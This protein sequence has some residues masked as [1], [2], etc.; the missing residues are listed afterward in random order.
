MISGSPVPH[1]EL[2]P[3][4][5]MCS[6]WCVESVKRTGLRGL[7]WSRLS[8]RRLRTETRWNL[9]VRAPASTPPWSWETKTNP[10][11]SDSPWCRILG[12]SRTSVCDLQLRF[13]TIS[14]GTESSLLAP[15][16]P[17]WGGEI[18]T[19]LLVDTLYLRKFKND[20]VRTHCYLQH[21]DH[22]HLNGTV[23]KGDSLWKDTNMKTDT[24]V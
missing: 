14:E 5:R 18:K 23:E 9:G 2:G 22:H 10:V 24:Q 6:V 11:N 13:V 7:C 21:P 16:R 17:N 12:N 1:S 3:H 19:S 20:P 4:T 8:A 15:W